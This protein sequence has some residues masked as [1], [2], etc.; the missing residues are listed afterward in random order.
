MYIVVCC[1]SYYAHCVLYDT[2]YPKSFEQSL[3]ASTTTPSVV[4][5]AALML[6]MMTFASNTIMS[7]SSTSFIL[8]FLSELL[9]DFLPR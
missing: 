4:C 2:I 6:P 5:R 3:P 1:Y 9:H 8:P 7:L